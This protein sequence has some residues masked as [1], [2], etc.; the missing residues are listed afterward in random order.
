MSIQKIKEHWELKAKEFLNNPNNEM[1]NTLYDENLR[2]LEINAILKYISP[3]SRVLDIGCGNGFS[4]IQFAKEKMIIIDGMDYSEEMINNAN[5]LLCNYPLLCNRI[6]FF[7][8]DILE[9]THK[10]KYD[11]II[12]ERC[13]INLETIENQKRAILNIKKM[14]NKNGKFIMLEGFEN[15]L[16]DIN[17]VRKKFNLDPIKVV[18]HNLFFEKNRFESFILPHFKID[19]IDNYGS[20]YMLLTRS[21]F[22]IIFNDQ[23][24]KSIDYLATLLPNLGDYNYQKLYI[25]SKK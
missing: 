21:L 3:N 5:T 14:L 19:T 23:F 13:L 20:T 2:R 1:G 24:D 7:Q 6:R 4:T 16:N 11:I 15:N 9:C 22:H 8:G 12:T 25:L 18:W 10:E 17:E